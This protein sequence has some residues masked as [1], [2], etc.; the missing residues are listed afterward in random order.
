MRLNCRKKTTSTT[1]LLLLLDLTFSQNGIQ[2]NPY[3]IPWQFNNASFH[4][5]HTPMHLWLLSVSKINMISRHG[6]AVEL[7]EGGGR[8]GGEGVREKVSCWR[9]LWFGYRM[10]ILILLVPNWSAGLVFRIILSLLIRTYKSS[11]WVIIGK[12]GLVK[13]YVILSTTQQRIISFHS[14]HYNMPLSFSILFCLVSFC[15]GLGK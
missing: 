15:S 1:D 13:S 10:L 6:K 2:W 5:R 11:S 3:P 12:F 9:W 4:I 14:I 8:W 7:M